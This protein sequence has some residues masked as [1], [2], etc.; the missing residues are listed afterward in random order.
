MCSRISPMAFEKKV[1]MILK[2]GKNDYLR[3]IKNSRE[4]VYNHKVNTIDL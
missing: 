3:N 4:Y 1:H 2:M